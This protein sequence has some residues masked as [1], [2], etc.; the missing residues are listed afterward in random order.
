MTTF[1][2]DI[3]PSGRSKEAAV[4]GAPLLHIP[5]QDLTKNA[6]SQPVKEE[7]KAAG[8][9]H[10]F[11]LMGELVDLY[12]MTCEDFVALRETVL[13]LLDECSQQSKND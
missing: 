7:E 3:K 9:A 4:T 12:S 1:E 10:I 2:D 11:K 5:T 8:R 13:E 6:P